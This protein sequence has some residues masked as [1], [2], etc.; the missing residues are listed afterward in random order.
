MRVRAR[1]SSWRFSEEV[2]RE[3]WTGHLEE[4]INLQQAR[5]GRS[6]IGS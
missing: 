5:A 1:K 4:L 6:K 3:A 2:F